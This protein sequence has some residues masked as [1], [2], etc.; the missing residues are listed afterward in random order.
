MPLPL[1]RLDRRTFAELV[2]EGQALLPLYAPPWT[3][4]N[5]HDPGITLLELLAAAV[6]VESFRLDRTPAATLRA[7]LRLVG[8]EVAPLQTARTVLSLAWGAGGVLAL[9]AGLQVAANNGAAIF[10]TEAALNVS[11]A[12]LVALLAGPP[13]ALADVRAA[14]AAAAGYAPLGPEPQ[15]DAALYLG[16]DRPLADEAVELALYVW[17]GPPAADEAL[18]ARLI[19]AWEEERADP[20]P[21]GL[22]RDL[23]DWRAHYRART[24]WEYYAAGGVWRPLDAVADETRGLTLS[25][26]VRFRAPLDHAAG[27]PQAT[28]FFLRCRLAAGGYECPPQIA[29]VALNPAPAR[30]AAALPRERLGVSTGAAGQRAALAHSPVAPGSTALRV[31]PDAGHEE[32]WAEVLS[33]DHSGPHDRHYLLDP[34][35]GLIS[36]GDGRV[37][38]VPPAGSVIS[39]GYRLGGGPAGNLRAGSLT[40]LADSPHNAALL[41]GWAAVVADLRVSQPLAAHG[42]AAA[43]RLSAAQGR[44]IDSL[45][46]VERAV[47]LDDYEALALDTP[48]VPLA[49]A[50]AL[51]GH[52]PDLPCFPAAG[53]VTVVVVPACPDPRPAPSAE[54]LRAVARHLGRRR[55]L[56][57]ELHVIGPQFTTVRVSARLRAASPG[58]AAGLAE[59]ARAALDQ[60]FHPLRGGP[61]GAGWPVGRDIYRAEVQA[62]LQ[63]LP[64]VAAVERLGLQGD[65][66][67]EPRCG[68]LPICRDSLVVSGRHQ[69]EIAERSAP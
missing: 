56:T 14:N 21:P 67:S 4:H 39:V 37:G 52:H 12:R 6:E 24:V 11:P 30:H 44:A 46:A 36:F 51:A 60:L 19:A 10:Q 2:A 18:R 22:A 32:G 42:G 3:D 35:Q 59:R 15:A 63:S 62:L 7:F 16:F 61:D 20:C 34:E 68:N 40:R 8:V 49:R 13:G 9:P 58:A 66:D 28:P 23:P 45:A 29:A 47:T 1:P 17:A 33:W 27:G 38:R 5:L 69:I 25:G 48:G 43:E 50:R 64:G 31:D 65:G 57:T 54:L 53:V 26:P 41:P 55:S